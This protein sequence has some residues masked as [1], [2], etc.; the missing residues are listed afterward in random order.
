MDLKAHL[1]ELAEL[2]G[3]SGYEDQ[4][5]E[6]LAKTWQPLVD[7][8]EVGKLG[9]LIGLKR[10]SGPEPR[11][12]LMLCA[13]IDEVGLIVKNIEEGFLRVSHLGG[14]DRR[15]LAG[16][17]VQ[18]H[19][20]RL[21]PGVVGVHPWHT[22]STEQREKYPAMTDLLVDVG[23]PAD[24]VAQLVSVGDV[25]TLDAPVI[26]LQNKR[27]VG[28]AF[29]D[30]ACVAAVTA[31]LDLLQSRKHSWDV[32]A[33]ASTQEEVGGFGAMT[34]AYRLQPDIAIALD[35]TFGTQP[36]VSGGDYAVGGGPALSLGANFHP[37][38]YEAINAA[39]E[40]IEMTLHP[41]PLPAHSGTDAWPIQISQNGIPSALLNIP[42]R[43]MHS[44]VETVDVKDIER[45]GR[46]LAEFIAGLTPEFLATIVWD[47]AEPEEKENA[48]V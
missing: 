31:C 27:I 4:V 38:L 37:V 32:L 35:V 28:K 44:S 40:R 5:R 19:G 26:E 12:R 39:A 30:R 47:A 21:L 25:I 2:H 1:K 41:D 45:A 46:V 36:G 15:I 6:A 34:E 3:P 17:A 9:S 14:I 22:L 11:R 13:H 20:R 29:D 18:V 43:N 7:T 48:K 23:L 16:K 24:Q 10:G 8:L 42:I 33:V